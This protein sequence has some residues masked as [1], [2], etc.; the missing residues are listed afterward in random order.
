MSALAITGTIGSGKSEVLQLLSPLLAI[1]ED[2]IYSSDREN[3]HLLDHNT[4]V[5]ELIISLLGPSSYQENG[6][7]DRSRIFELI[8]RDSSL[9]TALEN[10]LHPRLEILWKPKAAKY[11]SNHSSIFLAEIP[12]LYEKN[13]ELFFD[14]VIVVSCSDTI[15]ESRLHRFRSL[16]SDEIEAWIKMQESSEIK[17]SKAD[18]LIWN[19][20]SH[21]ALKHQIHLLASHLLSL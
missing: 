13:L 11:R 3:R 2:Q 6:T 19:D 18:Y 4:E 20:G 1:K 9:R 5:R 8:S 15:R 17:I 12:L 21:S 16:N 10:I 7:A 14:K